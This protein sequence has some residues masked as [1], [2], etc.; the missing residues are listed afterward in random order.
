MSFLSTDGIAPGVSVNDLYISYVSLPI[1]S[2]YFLQSE[3]NTVQHAE[4]PELDHQLYIQNIY[5]NSVS[6]KTVVPG[7]IPDSLIPLEFLDTLKSFN[8][9]SYDLGWIQTQETR[10]K[11]NNHFN[12]A[13]NYFQQNN[14]FAAKSELQL[15]L[16]ECNADSSNVLT[17]EAYALLY[18]NT[19]YLI[20]QIPDTE[21]GLPVKLHDSQG[22]LLQGGS[23]QYYDGSW[24]D[25]VNN[26]DGTFNVITERTTVSIRMT[27]EGGNQQFNN[28]PVGPLDTVTF[29]TVNTTAK[30]LNS[31]NELLPEG[32]VQ[33]YAG[34]W[35]EFGTIV[36]GTASK[37]L[38]PRQYSF[39]MTY[40]GANNDKQQNIG[41][42]PVV[43][44]QTVNATVQLLD[45][46][47]TLIS[48]TVCVEYY[49]GSW[50]DFGT[51]SNGTVSKELLPKQYSF[52]MTH[53]GVNNDKQQ[54]IGVEDTVRFLTVLCFVQV[55]D[56]QDQPIDGAEVKYYSGSWRDIGLTA[57][58]E[59]SKE[60]LPKNLSFRIIYNGVTQNKQQDLG[61]NSI[62][63]FVVE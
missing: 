44:F 32:Q 47:G 13:K 56:A 60:L 16:N 7:K 24:K 62:V 46:Q 18:F 39:R 49:A 10:D 34:S 45:S 21:P 28:V 51:T 38:L 15:V 33:F 31:Q 57:N 43:V 20:E 26:G 59:V 42:D 37:E 19:E 53:E 8:T 9:Q 2:S 30:L 48:E 58:G 5:D 29:Q 35:R 61:T 3:L 17:S 55:K 6:G 11:Y 4:D 50:R 40:G 14:N 52:R 54:D 23:L 63:E 22:N 25:A 36:N 27:Y 41:T 1:I 12:N